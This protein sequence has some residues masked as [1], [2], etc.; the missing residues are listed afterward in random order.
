[1]RPAL[2]FISGKII[3]KKGSENM[4]LPAKAIIIASAIDK[5]IVKVLIP[6]EILVLEVLTNQLSN[7]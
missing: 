7:K 5:I 4:Y 2:V 6:L 3:N 1:V